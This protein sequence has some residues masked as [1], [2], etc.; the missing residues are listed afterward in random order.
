MFCTQN[1]TIFS[2]PWS[3]TNIYIRVFLF[4]KQFYTSTI[5]IHARMLHVLG[6]ST[7]DRTVVG[8]YHFYITDGKK[9]PFTFSLHTVNFKTMFL[10]HELTLYQLFE[11]VDLIHTN[12]STF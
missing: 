6:R 3:H 10:L 1:V 5:L 12:F 8:P 2:I 9:Y 4:V 11:H 7:K